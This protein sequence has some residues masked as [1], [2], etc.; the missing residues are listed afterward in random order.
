MTDT[1]TDDKKT[2]KEEN[3][4]AEKARKTKADAKKK[5]AAM[6]EHAKRMAKVKELKKMTDT[7]GWQELYQT[8]QKQIAAHAEGVLDYT[9]G[10]KDVMYH[11]QSVRV[12][13]DLITRVRAPVD[14][15]KG[16]ES[17]MS[18]FVAAS[19]IEESATFD[20][21]TGAVIIE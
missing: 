13:R 11:Q 18:L 9:L 16:Y 1:K 8:M 12:L 15:L 2:N 10:S 21:K 6:S 4:A 17:E 5:K 7:K 19:E 20:D 3:D 14:S